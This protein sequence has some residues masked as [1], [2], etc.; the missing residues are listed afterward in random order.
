MHSEL[1]CLRP[2]VRPSH[3]ARLAFDC[4]I[5]VAL[6]AASVGVATGLRFRR[7]S[8]SCPADGAAVVVAESRIAWWAL[9]VG[10][11]FGQPKKR[12]CWWAPAG[13]SA[14]SSLNLLCLCCAAH[15][16]LLELWLALPIGPTEWRNT[17]AWQERQLCVCQLEN[18]PTGAP[19]HQIQYRSLRG[20]AGSG[21]EHIASCG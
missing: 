19:G 2:I 13:E 15:Q 17:A 21:M 8:A 5:G 7:G 10:A 6:S 20:I 16:T 14:F 18:N 12:Q 3:R 9:V 4:L 1:R 11:A